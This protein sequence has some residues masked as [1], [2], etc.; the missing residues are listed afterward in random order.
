[1]AEAAS[2]RTKKLEKVASSENLEVAKFGGFNSAICSVHG[3]LRW[4]GFDTFLNNFI[5][6]WSLPD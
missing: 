4:F 6:F 5:G 2:L 3:I 1:V